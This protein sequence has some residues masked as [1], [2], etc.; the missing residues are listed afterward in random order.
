MTL[1]LNENWEKKTIDGEKGEKFGNWYYQVTTNSPWNY[2][3]KLDML[4]TENI[5]DNFI[6]EKKENIASYPWTWE[7]APITIKAKAHKVNGWTLYRGST[8][9][10]PYYTQMGNDIGEEETIE[11]IPYGCTTLRITEFPVR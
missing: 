4:K 11:L 8:G 5:T 3:F 6:V 9:K 1:K 2:A 7:D 10:V